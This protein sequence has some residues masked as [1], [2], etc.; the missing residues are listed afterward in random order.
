MK[1]MRAVRRYTE[2][3]FRLAEE[4]REV[5]RV[6]QDLEGVAGFFKQYPQV[7]RFLT[8]PAV[9][10]QERKAW[11]RKH[12]AKKLSRLTVRFLE[13]LIAKGRGDLF[14]DVQRAFDRRVRAARGEVEVRITSTRPLN[15]DLQAKLK[16]SFEKR[17]KSRIILE[18]AVDG[19]L[20]AGAVAEYGNKVIDGCAL[21]RL[22]EMR[23]RLLTAEA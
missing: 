17:L 18:L 4:E 11:V 2:A 1:E 12:L 13:V 9:G 10:R 7:H 6:S 5:K 8:S 15:K 3:L 20:L 21:T 14:G 19:D 16:S 22:N 23:S